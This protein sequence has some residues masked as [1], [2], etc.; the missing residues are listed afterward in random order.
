MDVS[1]EIHL[2]IEEIQRLG[3]KSESMLQLCVE[4][5]CVLSWITLAYQTILKPLHAVDSNKCCDVTQICNSS[6][7]IAKK[8][9]LKNNNQFT[10]S[11]DVGKKNR[12]LLFKCAGSTFCN[13]SA[14]CFSQC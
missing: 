8:A 11:F 14:C 3:N 10:N 4:G 2:L 7:I 6:P 1:H 13:I 5:C 12:F 9:N